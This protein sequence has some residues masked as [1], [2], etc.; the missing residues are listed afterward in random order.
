MNENVTRR[1]ENRD[2]IT[3]EPGAHP[4]GTGVG[5]AG[6]GLAGAAAGMAVG[7]PIGGA[8][9][10]VV[11]AVAGGAGGKAVAEAV[12]PTAEDAYWRE[13]HRKESYFDRNRSYEDY[14]PAYRTGYEG[15]DRY[16]GEG[17]TFD[18]AEPDLRSDYEKRSG[19][20]KW[21]EARP[22]ARAA[23]NRIENRRDR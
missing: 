23:W 15:F 20:M 8:I 22:A 16:Y 18:A 19:T 13:N 17:T 7:G 11:G 5:A 2:P 12:D 14:S 10:A 3:G 4:V 6:A 1:D 9:G 21:D